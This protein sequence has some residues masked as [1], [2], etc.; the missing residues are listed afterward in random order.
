MFRRRDRRE[1]PE[2]SEVQED[3]AI[4]E[5]ELDDTEPGDLPE[6]MTA[7]L[8]S[9][10]ADYLAGNDVWMYGPNAE[11]VLE[12]LDRLEEIGPSDAGPIV[13]AWQAIPKPDRAQARKAV[14]KLTE[15]DEESLRHFQLAR[16]AIGAW[17]SVKGP[18]PEFVNVEPDW[19]R[20]CS[21]VGEAALDAATALILEDKLEE[22]DY[23]ALLEPWSEA[24]AE[25]DGA[26]DGAPIDAG[27]GN[28]GSD[29][30][31]A[32]DDEEE[33]TEEERKFGPN[34]DS[35]ADFLNRLWLLTPEQIGRLVSGWQNTERDDLKTAHDALRALV[36]ED[37][38]WHDQVRRAQE[39]LSPWL[40]AGRFQDSSG[41]LGQT[42]QNES[43]KMAGPTL[44]DAVAALVLGDMLEPEDAETLY[45]PWFNLIG[46]P[47]LPV[48]AEDGEPDVPAEP[49]KAAPA[50]AAPAKAPPKSAKA[51]PESSAKPATKSK[52][53]GK[54]TK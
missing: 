13:Q 32:D 47:E 24:M 39:E 7:D 35:L 2:G 50:K 45:G 12:I 21:Q 27:T 52:T 18:F 44:A 25:L 8:E 28:E 5:A 48:A 23:E 9:Q 29:D 3:A 38:E 20:L 31:E 33:D 54:S 42:G 30:D 34:S 6:D 15:N 51:A 16:E 22:P 37:P 14:K 53:T 17:M 10:A 19:P 4:E 11:D 40:N 26:A 43:R 1:D 46:G 49:P 41:F 36:D